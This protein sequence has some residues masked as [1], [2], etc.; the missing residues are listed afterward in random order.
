MSRVF[1]S[2]REASNFAKKESLATKVL[3]SVTRYGSNWEVSSK[4]SKHK[5]SPESEKQIELRKK[6][7]ELEEEIKALDEIE[8]K[9]QE[10]EKERR[11]EEKRQEKEKERRA[12]EKRQEKEKERREEER[13]KFYENAELLKKLSWSQGQ[14]LI[15]AFALRPDQVSD[16]LLKVVKDKNFFKLVTKEEFLNLFELKHKYR[17]RLVKVRRAEE[18]RREKERAKFYERAELLKK[19]TFSQERILIEAFALRPDQVSDEFFKVVKDKN[20]FKLVTKEEFLNHFE[21]KHKSWIERYVKQHRQKIEEKRDSIF[22]VTKEKYLAMS[23]EELD[24][25]WA[26]ADDLPK[27]ERQL[28]RSILRHVK[29]IDK[30]MTLDRVPYFCSSCGM[31]VDNCT[32]GGRS[33]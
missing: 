10:K 1:D 2:F 26:N 22:K 25:K 16:E 27:S 29:G 12:E 7:I 30:L 5:P 8:E 21:L 11:A 6:I 4:G 32:C 9:R 33:W 19:I 17:I 14:T 3:H 20:F 23:E 31:H 18:E 28:L 13:A 15:E 24:E